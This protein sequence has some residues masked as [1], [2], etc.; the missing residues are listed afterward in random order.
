MKD[1]LGDKFDKT[2][3][4]AS[5]EPLHHSAS[6]LEGLV[7][8]TQAFWTASIVDMLPMDGLLCK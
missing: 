3:V 7:Y 1:V 4:T 5:Y 6:I 8:D 2:V